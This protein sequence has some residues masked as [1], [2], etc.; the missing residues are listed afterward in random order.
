MD[1]EMLKSERETLR[2]QLRELEQEQ[3]KLEADLKSFRQR[4]I[5]TK[6]EIEALSTLIEINE[7]R[8]EGE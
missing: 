4:E 5:Q 1:L 8:N 3:R 7:S 6:R 2:E